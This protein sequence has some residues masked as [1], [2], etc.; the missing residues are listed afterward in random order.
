MTNI[1]QNKLTKKLVLLAALMGA[2]AY[3]RTPDQAQ[4]E[5][6]QQQCEAQDQQCF[7]FC[8]GNLPCE[9]LC[10]AAYERCLIACN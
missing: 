6:C 9:N 10:A 7:K 3:L 5:T 4:A 8:D 2:L 1:L